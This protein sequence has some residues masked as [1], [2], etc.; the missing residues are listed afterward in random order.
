MLHIYRSSLHSSYKHSCLLLFA[1]HYQN[2]IKHGQQQP[3]CH[4]SKNYLP[5][6]IFI[7]FF[8]L[9]RCASGFV[10]CKKCK[11]PCRACCLACIFLCCMVLWVSCTPAYCAVSYIQNIVLFFS[12]IFLVSLFVAVHFLHASL[13]FRFRGCFSR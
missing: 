2:A 10:L 6:F 13:W 8:T 1:C 11:L 3:H 4:F 12:G 9:F 5:S 7:A